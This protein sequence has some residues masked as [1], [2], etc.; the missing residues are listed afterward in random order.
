VYRRYY[1]RPLPWVGMDG[2]VRGRSILINT[3]VDVCEYASLL[4]HKQKEWVLP[5]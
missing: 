5:L 4:A 1:A 3:Q 2:G